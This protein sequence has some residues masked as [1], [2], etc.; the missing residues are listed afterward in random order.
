LAV[1]WQ[2]SLQKRADENDDQK[3][4]ELNA[5]DKPLRG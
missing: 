5:H 1:L 3:N 2:D 4:S